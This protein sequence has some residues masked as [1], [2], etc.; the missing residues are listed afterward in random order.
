MFGDESTELSHSRKTEEVFEDIDIFTLL[1]HVTQKNYPNT[2]IQKPK[3]FNSF[4]IL[5]SASLSFFSFL[6][7]L[8]SFSSSTDLEPSNSLVAW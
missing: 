4:D 1:Q 6:I 2:Q 8:S 3:L 7:L 5:S